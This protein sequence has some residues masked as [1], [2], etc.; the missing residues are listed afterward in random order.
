MGHLLFLQGRV[1]K[2]LMHRYEVESQ[3][4]GKSSFA[5]AW[6]LDET[7]EE[8]ARGITTD[9]AVN[10][11]WDRFRP[12]AHVLAPRF[13]NTDLTLS[14]RSCLFFRSVSAACPVFETPTKK[15]TLL[16]A[17]GHK[18]FIPRMITGAAQADAGILVIPATKG[19]F[20]GGWSEDGQ[21]RE[22]AVLARSLGVSQLIL[23]INK[24]DTCGWSQA[25][26]DEI[27]SQLIPWLKS[28]GYKAQDLSVIPLS[29][30]TGENIMK[31]SEPGL[32]WYNGP[33]LLDLIDQFHAPPR[34]V[35]LPL[36]MCVQDVFKTLSLGQAVAGKV[37]TGTILPR[38]RLLLLPLNET[39]VVKCMES[40]GEL[41]NIARAGDN[42]ELGLKDFSD[43]AVLQVG[44]WLCDPLHP[45]PM[46]VHFRAQII[47]MANFK[48]PLLAGTQLVF[49][50][51]ACAETVSLHSLH[52]IIDKTTGAVLKRNPRVIPKS[53]TAIVELTS[54]NKICLELFRSV[55]SLGRFS[56]RRGQETV[57]CGIVTSHTNTAHTQ[58]HRGRERGEEQRALATGLR[59]TLAFL[60][61]FVRRIVSHAVGSSAL[62][63]L[64]FPIAPSHA[65][66]AL[67][68]E[69]LA[70]SRRRYHWHS[71]RAKARRNQL[72]Y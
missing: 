22:H 12:R 63:F 5:F 14:L 55:K 53:A 28:V 41:L 31:R 62:A 7:E 19:E 13:A 4:Q 30:L 10:C 65:D 9:V 47:T 46:V 25:R 36:R 64:S 48:V 72:Q 27:V 68:S 71:P 50:N 3:Q 32:S 38:D 54:K 17:P 1:S 15:I 29:G 20:E 34:Q 57:A 70:R 59:L 52:S 33:V 56:L 24:L 49:F 42:I 21:I 66:N 43:P 61:L 6:V 35:D 45:I 51:Q 2:K 8:R 40:R 16:D 60:C 39:V 11:K 69:P 67:E 58:Q 18:E 23:A 44:Q 26:Y 37:E